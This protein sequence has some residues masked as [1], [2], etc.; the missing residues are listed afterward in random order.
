[1]SVALSKETELSRFGFNSVEVVTFVIA[2]AI[3]AIVLL[4]LLPPKLLLRLE[5]LDL[6]PLREVRLCTIELFLFVN[7]E[8]ELFVDAEELETVFVNDVEEGIFKWL[9]LLVLLLNC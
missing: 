3:E 1:V 7:E 8:E 6:L 5:I 2:D 9:I 4:L